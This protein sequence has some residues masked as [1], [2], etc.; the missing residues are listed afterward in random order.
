MKYAFPRNHK[1]CYGVFSEKAE[2]TARKAGFEVCE[3]LLLTHKKKPILEQKLTRGLVLYL[4]HMWAAFT[5]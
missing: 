4:A 1:A 3:E 5:S 2:N